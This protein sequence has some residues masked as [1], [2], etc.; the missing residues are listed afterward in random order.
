M[1]FIYNYI[2]EE[3][4]FILDHEIL[5]SENLENMYQCCK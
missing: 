4:Q 3:L 1:V 5:Y 2:T